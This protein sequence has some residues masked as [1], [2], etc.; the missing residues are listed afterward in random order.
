MYFVQDNAGRLS[1]I[2]HADAAVNANADGGSLKI[3][4]GAE[5][6]ANRGVELELFDDLGARNFSD[7]S[8]FGSCA[9]VNR[10]CHSWDTSV[11]MGY[12]AWRWVRKP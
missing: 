5:D 8:W 10:D 7:G 12:F 11:G 4:V 9:N 6:I 3:F 2:V 1:L